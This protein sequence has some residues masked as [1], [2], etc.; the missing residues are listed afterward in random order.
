MPD[1][2][3]V[4]RACAYVVPKRGETVTFDD[5]VS[6]LKG[7]VASYKLPERLESIDE[8]PLVAGGSAMPKVDKKILRADI[9]EKLK[10]E[11]K[12]PDA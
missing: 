3:M 10:M 1:P 11:G 5:M 9:I 7:K 4:E 8:L 2:V 12:L 6:F